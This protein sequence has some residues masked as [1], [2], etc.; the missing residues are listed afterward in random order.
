MTKRVGLI[1]VHGV[2]NQ[3]RYDLL[4]EASSAF[5][6]TLKTI[7]PDEAAKPEFIV[8]KGELYRKATHSREAGDPV[9]RL[10]ADQADRLFRPVTIRYRQSEISFY[11]VYWADLDFRYSFYEKIKYNL[12][13]LTI[14]WNPFFNKMT[15]RY[16]RPRMPWWKVLG[17]QVWIFG[18]GALY[19]L[20]EGIFLLLPFVSRS[21]LDESSRRWVQTIYE[22]A[23]DVKLYVSPRIIF[24]DQTKKDVIQARFDEVLVKALLETDEVHVVGASL[25][26]VIAFDGLSR[27]RVH[28]SKM[29]ND[30][31]SYLQRNHAGQ[32]DVD[33]GEKVQTFVTLGSPLDKF[34]FLWPSRRGDGVQGSFSIRGDADP[35]TGLTAWEAEMNPRD[36]QSPAGSFKWLNFKD[37]VDPLGGRLNSYDELEFPRPENHRFAFRY[38]PSRGHVDY[39]R[40]RPFMRWLIGRTCPDAPEA[41]PPHERVN[42][43][44]VARVAFCFAWSLGGAA[45]LLYLFVVSSDFVLSLVHDFYVNA[46]SQTVYVTLDWLDAVVRGARAALGLEERSVISVLAGLGRLAL[47]G[48]VATLPFSAWFYRK[49]EHEIRRRTVPVTPEVDA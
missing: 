33:P 17:L 36:A 9:T 46:E 6:E 27:H 12:W 48:A 26:S 19:H 11:E 42:L 38:W 22:Y 8:D 20:A 24:H 1:L 45:L 28:P 23:G 37:L 4:K 41:P 49:S 44:W 3:E 39:W 21:R 10:Q 31:L 47:I 16:R 14:I 5:Y 30:L 15:G 29:S 25:G 2:G 7:E 13:L 43:G 35:Q 34:Y 18:L 32:A 40:Y